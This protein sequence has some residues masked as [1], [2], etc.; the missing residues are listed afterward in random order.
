MAA[1]E[2]PVTVASDRQEQQL[3]TRDGVA[4]SYVSFRFPLPSGVPAHSEA[5]DG[6]GYLRYRPVGGPE[7]SRVA[8]AVVVQQNVDSIIR[9][10]T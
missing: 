2:P 8:D 4:V 5:C 10:P 3:A 7:N 6:T 1:D 9:G